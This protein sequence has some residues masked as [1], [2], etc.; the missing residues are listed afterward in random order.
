MCDESGHTKFSFFRIL[1][2]RRYSPWLSSCSVYLLWQARA[3]LCFTLI[4][5]F[6]RLQH[7][8]PESL[9]GGAQNW[10]HTCIKMAK[11]VFHF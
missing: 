7:S 5:I 6:A 4:T 10:S 11:N 1:S 3:H 2:T 9:Q 8:L